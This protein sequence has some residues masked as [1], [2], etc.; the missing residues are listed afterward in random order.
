MF[1]NI[2]NILLPQ[3]SDKKNNPLS[4]FEKQV[5]EEGGLLQRSRA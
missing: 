4:G 5:G 2:I 3:R 1:T